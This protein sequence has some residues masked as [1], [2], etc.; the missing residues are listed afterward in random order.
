MKLD[1]IDIGKLSLADVPKFK[2]CPCELCD[3]GCFEHSGNE[4]YPGCRRRF[5]QRNK[6]TKSA[7][8]PSTHYR[9]TYLAADANQDALAERRFPCPPA[10]DN[11]IPT[12]FKNVPMSNKSS[13]R[14]D[15]QAP[16]AGTLKQSMI[17]PQRSVRYLFVFFQIFLIEQ[18]CYRLN[19]QICHVQFR[20]KRDRSINLNSL[21]NQ[22]YLFLFTLTKIL[23]LEN[24][25]SL[26]I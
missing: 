3:D 2:E 6:T 11:P 26:C 4:H 25:L 14:E 5:P 18:L 16:P 20:W 8:F 17:Y 10:P 24:D 12:S 9:S 21:R 13:Q 7:H 19:I 22:L 1:N 23:S 15:Y